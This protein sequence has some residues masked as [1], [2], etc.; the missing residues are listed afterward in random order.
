MR[1]GAS[2]MTVSRWGLCPVVDAT[3]QYCARPSGHSGPH[4]LACPEI[5]GFGQRCSLIAGHAGAHMA[6]L[7][8]PG[9][10]AGPPPAAMRPPA[11]QNAGVMGIGKGWSTAQRGLALL[12]IVVVA[13]AL[14]GRGSTPVTSGGGGGGGAAPAA[15][16]T[17]LDLKGSGIQT[18]AK[19][20]AQ[21]DW[22]INWSY[23]CIGSSFGQA[24]NFII[25]V[26]GDSSVPGVNQLGPSGSGIEPVYQGGTFYLEMNSECDWHVTVRG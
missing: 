11:V 23:D 8:F 19:F 18:S 12:V 3:G 6:A 26:Q 20:T 16:R 21:G 24:G 4:Q 14:F 2:A 1:E 25:N 5:D 15:P 13:I 17:L 22:A 9:A 7:S 10:A